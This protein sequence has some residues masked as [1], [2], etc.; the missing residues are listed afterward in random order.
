MLIVSTLHRSGFKVITT[1]NPDSF[2]HVKSLGADAAFDYK[3]PNVGSSI[4]DYTENRLKYAWDTIS[5]DSSARICANALSSNESG[6]RYGT[7]NPVKMPRD[8]VETTMT[9]MYTVFGKAFKFGE[10]E[11]PASNDDFEFAKMFTSLTE[12]LM[13]QVS[14]H[15]AAVHLPSAEAHC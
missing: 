10:Q 14:K 3:Q 11:M 5:I 7:I 8:D 15:R 9:V 1:C 2:D 13:A 12:R 4:R 6:L